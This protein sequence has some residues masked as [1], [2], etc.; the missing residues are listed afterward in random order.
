ME[1]NIL[2]TNA[3]SLSPVWPE[4][5]DSLDRRALS[6]PRLFARVVRLARNYDAVVLDGST[7]WR[8]GYVDL[9]AAALIAHLP[10]GPAVVIT[11]CSW[12]RGRNVFDHVACRLGLKLLDTKNVRYCVRSRDE[13]QLLPATWGMNPARVVLTPYGHTLTEGELAQPATHDG[14]IFAGGN[15]LRD[16]ET[17]ID[18]VRGL[19]TN[20]TIATS[21]R[22][23]GIPENVKIVPVTPHDRFIDLMRHAKVVVVPFGAGI[24]RAAGLDTYLSAM[25][26]GKVVVVTECPG[27]RDYIED[28]VNGVIVPAADPAAMRAAIEWAVDPGNAAEVNAMREGARQIAR[29]EFSFARH[30]EILLSVVDDAIESNEQRMST[31]ADL[32]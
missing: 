22:V 14:G 21:L 29:E 6:T 26:L 32:S 16:Y 1:R 28:R 23:G 25:A 27:T 30:A 7:G 13:L 4:R 5:V 12:K 11:D 10:G 17:L 8:T 2:S 18:A 20:V 9:L 15:A 19:E 3:Y 24:T 31:A